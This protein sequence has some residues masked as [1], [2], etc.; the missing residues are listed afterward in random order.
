[1]GPGT[2]WDDSLSMESRCVPRGHFLVFGENMACHGGGGHS[3][4]LGE[5]PSLPAI[6][7]GPGWPQMQTVLRCAGP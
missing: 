7:L 6:L 2:S 1:M 3:W 4:L 5:A